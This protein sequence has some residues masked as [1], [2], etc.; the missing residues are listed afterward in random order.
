MATT[1]TH[2]GFGPCNRRR[3]DFERLFITARVDRQLGVVMITRAGQVRFLAAPSLAEITSPARDF[4]PVTRLA[5]CQPGNSNVRKSMSDNKTENQYRF[6]G[7]VKLKKLPSR[8]ELRSL[9]DYLPQGILIRKST[10]KPVYLRLNRGRYIVYINSESYRLSRVIYAWHFSDP[11]NLQIDHINGNKKDDRIENLRVATNSQNNAAKCNSKGYFKNKNGK[12]VV[13]IMKDGKHNRLGTFANEKL[14][15]D[16]AFKLKIILF[17][18]FAS[19]NRKTKNK[20]NFKIT[21]LF[22][23][24]S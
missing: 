5:R 4:D 22:G 6:A 21:N 24:A 19:P 9:F 15:A 11:G 13:D 12:W 2:D 7:K 1:I 18:D 8:E 17:G 14:A 16:L 3:T 20:Q 10:N 23:D